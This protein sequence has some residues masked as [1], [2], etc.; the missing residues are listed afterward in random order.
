MTEKESKKKEV[1]IWNNWT[2]SHLNWPNWFY[3][4]L[5]SK[6]IKK[7]HSLQV[8]E[9][10]PRGITNIYVSYLLLHNK[11]CQNLINKNNKHSL[12]HSFC[13]SRIWEQLSSVVLA[14]GLLWCYCSQCVSWGYVHQNC[15][16]RGVLLSR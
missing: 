15:W 7:T 2:N 3:E 16:L 11:F 1:S 9:H 14:M 4:I 8:T 10:S 12:W 13:E 5:H 6:R